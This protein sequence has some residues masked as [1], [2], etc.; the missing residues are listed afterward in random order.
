M[1]VAQK[2]KVG[3]FRSCSKIKVGQNVNVKV[4]KCHC[5]ILEAKGISTLKLQISIIVIHAYLQVVPYHCQ[6]WV[7]FDQNQ[8]NGSGGDVPTRL[9]LND[10]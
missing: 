10:T 4:S 1:N 5:A 9:L 8:L 3:Q 2:Y 7:K 6:D